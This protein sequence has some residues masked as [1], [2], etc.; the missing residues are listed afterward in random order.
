MKFESGSESIISE[1]S[2]ARGDTLR[3]IKVDVKKPIRYVSMRIKNQYEFTGL[4][5]YENKD[6]A[7]VDES[8]ADIG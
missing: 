8:W 3:T 1:L 4:R 2:D 6:E 7:F 5:L